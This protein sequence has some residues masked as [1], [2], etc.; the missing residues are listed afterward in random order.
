M[1]RHRRLPQRI[2]LTCSRGANAV[3]SCAPSVAAPGSHL[4]LAAAQRWKSRGGGACMCRLQTVRGCATQEQRLC[5]DASSSDS[6]GGMLTDGVGAGG[7][8]RRKE[9]AVGLR[10]CR[11]AQFDADIS[12][13]QH[14]G[15]YRA[16]MHG[17]NAQHA[18]CCTRCRHACQG[19]VPRT[20]CCFQYKDSSSTFSRQDAPAPPADAETR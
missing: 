18:K 16:T 11:S 19:G 8:L 3:L 5:I 17:N 4:G 2:V 14:M 15:Q 10:Q 12:G 6:S 1:V 20:H 13:Q 9:A 7:P